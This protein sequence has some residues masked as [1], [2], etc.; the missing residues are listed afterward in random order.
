MEHFSLLVL[1]DSSPL[2]VTVLELEL[3]PCTHPLGDCFF[4]SNVQKY[5][6]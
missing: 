5:V 2:H 4:E 6:C 1:C 3:K